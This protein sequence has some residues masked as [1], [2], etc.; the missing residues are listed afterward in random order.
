MHILVEG[1]EST[2]SKFAGDIKLGGG[3]THWKVVLPF[4]KTRKLN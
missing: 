4:N 3:L 1:I 2:L